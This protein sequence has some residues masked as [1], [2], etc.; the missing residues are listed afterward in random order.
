MSLPLPDNRCSPSICL[1]C[2]IHPALL[3]PAMFFR[4]PPA[5]PPPTSGLFRMFFH[6]QP[7]S[8]ITMQHLSGPSCQIVT[9][10]VAPIPI[11]SPSVGWCLLA[12]PLVAVTSSHLSPLQ[13]ESQASLPHLPMPHHLRCL[14]LVSA[15]HWLAFSQHLTSCR[16][17]IASTL[18][19]CPGHPT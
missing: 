4:M 15:P 8:F 11:A 5:L 1:I 13:C 16:P 6:A 3:H 10:M 17:P 2:S 7:H 14:P 12:F 9:I 19:L 18:F